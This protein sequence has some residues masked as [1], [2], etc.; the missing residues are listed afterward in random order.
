MSLPHSKLTFKPRFVPTIAALCVIGLTLYLGQWQQGRAAEKRLLQAAFDARSALPP[1][2]LNIA[3]ASP[4]SQYRAATASGTYDVAGQFFIDNKSEGMTVGYHVITPLQLADRQTWVLINRGFV[5]RGAHYPLPPEVEPTHGTVAVTG[6]L[7]S[8]TLKFFELGSGNVANAIQGSVW[9][10]LTIERYRQQTKRDIVPYVL[11]ANPS[12]AGLV[13][14]K[15]R[16]DAR[17]EKHVEYMLTWYSL[18]ATVVMLWLFLN[19]K[20]I[21]PAQPE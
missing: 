17:V 1:I 7:V 15:E 5:P 18:A 13:A 10:N 4:D 2:D 21:K 16:P 8:P 11:L 20:F 9:Q 14:Q 12:N 19:L 3:T 6:M